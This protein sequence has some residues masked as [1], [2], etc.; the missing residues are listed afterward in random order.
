MGA[1]LQ[2]AREHVIHWLASMKDSRKLT[3]FIRDVFAEGLRAKKKKD[4]AFGSQ[5]EH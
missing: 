2:R 5:K 1:A 3:H 4:V